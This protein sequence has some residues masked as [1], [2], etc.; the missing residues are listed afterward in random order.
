MVVGDVRLFKVGITDALLRVERSVGRALVV[1]LPV[2][3]VGEALTTKRVADA[4]YEA[5]GRIFGRM[6]SL[7]LH[8]LRGLV[9]AV[10]TF[11]RDLQM[12]WYGY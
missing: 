9:G 11:R 7:V 8:V 2:H 4:V 1:S 3:D 12:R 5:F 6:L 10:C